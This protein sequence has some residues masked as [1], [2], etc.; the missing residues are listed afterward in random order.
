MISQPKITVIILCWNGKQWLEACIES[1]KKNQATMPYEIMVVDNGSTDGSAG[2]IRAHH[3]D[4]DLIETGKNLGFAGGNNVGIN[5]ALEQG[6]EYIL[7]LNQDTVVFDDWMQALIDIAQSH[8]D[9]GI[10]SP[11]Q[12]DYEGSSLD[13]VFAEQLTTNTPH[14]DD[15]KNNAVPPVYDVPQVI[16]AAMLLRSTL[17]QTIGNFDPL[18]FL[19]FEEKDLCRRTL[20]AGY[21]IGVVP[22]SKIGHYHGRLHPN[23]TITDIDGYF[24]RNRQV[25]I[26]KDPTQLFWKNLYIYLRYGLPN[27]LKRKYDSPAQPPTFLKALHTQIE[28]ILNLPR[29]YLRRRWECKQIR[30]HSQR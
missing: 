8:P 20:T 27:S 3:T 5:Q 19:Y 28:I 11:F 1:L 30:N 22:K 17:L 21:R 24:L 6:A 23:K 29:I 13:R 7:L 18:Y 2:W 14:N 12:Y 25:F 4:I 16:G 9:F 10:L 15:K 26:L